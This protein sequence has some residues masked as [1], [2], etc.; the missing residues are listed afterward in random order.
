MES[1]R[2]AMK[3]AREALKRAHAEYMARL[4]VESGGCVSEAARIAGVN[5]TYF[6]R[7]RARV[8]AAK[9]LWK[10]GNRGNEQWHRLGH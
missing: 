6:Y 7:L 4:A 1:Y 8:G 9:A 5:R 3:P 10:T 2:E